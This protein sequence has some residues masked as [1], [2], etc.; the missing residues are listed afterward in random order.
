MGNILKVLFL[1]FIF[2]STIGYSQNLRKDFFQADFDSSYYS[3]LSREFGQ[4]KSL[5]KGYE[6]QALHALSYYPELKNVKI[7]FRVKKKNSPLMVRPTLGSSIFSSAKKRTYII[8]ISSSSAHMDSVLIEHLP[9]NAQV[10]VI[11][12]ELAHV[13]FF[14]GKG[15]WGMLRVAFGNLSGKYLNKIEFETDWSTIN[16][17]LGWQLLTWGD[18]VRDKLKMEKWKGV[19]EYIYGKAKT[20]RS[21]YMNPET[22]RAVMEDSP[23]YN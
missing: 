14:I 20:P 15:R 22:M 17:G 1:S 21:R 11:G 10:G 8:F 18:F 9:L 4:R 19:D 13:S 2:S 3:N 6:K 5:P 16:H 7:Q 23:L 12:H